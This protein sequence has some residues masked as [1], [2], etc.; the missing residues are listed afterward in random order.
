MTIASQKNI[1]GSSEPFS[2]PAEIRDLTGDAQLELDCQWS[3]NVNAFTQQA[4]AGDPWNSGYVNSQGKFVPS[5]VRSSYF[6]PATTDI[7]AGTLSHSIKWNAFPNRITTY[8]GANQPR[9]NP[10]NLTQHQLWQLG[11]TGYYTNAAGNKL[12]FPQIPVALY[13]GSDWNGALHPYGPYGPRGWQDEY[14]EWSVTRNS[15]GTI[16]RVDFVCENPEYW[17][18]LWRVSPQAVAQKYQDALNHGLPADSPDHVAVSAED[19]Y[20]ADPSSGQPVVDPFTGR[21]AYNPLNKWN[22]GATSTRGRN[23]SG[24]AIHLTSTPNTLHTELGLA[25]AATVQRMV[26]NVSAQPL[27]CCS[28]YGQE[29]RNSDPH[30]VQSVNQLVGG[31]PSSMVSL[32]N[33]VGLYIQMPNFSSY[34]LPSDPNLPAGASASDCWQIV[35]GTE[36]LTDPVTGQ[37]YP[38]NFILHAAFQVPAAWID[39]GVLFTV[40][41]ITISAGGEALPIH[42]ASQISETFDIGLFARALSVAAPTAR[43]CRIGLDKPAAP[44]HQAA[45]VQPMQLMYQALW[46]AYYN[47]PVANVIGF[48]MNLASNS[49]IVPVPVRQGDRGLQLVLTCGTTVG[50][51]DN[52]L[53]HVT[54]PGAEI[55]I[56]VNQVAGLLN[57]TYAAPGN[58]YP[59]GF[60]LLAL[61]VDVGANVKPGLYSV[62]V[63]NPGAGMPPAVPGPAF[64][65]VFPAQGGCAA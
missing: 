48:P 55:N 57:V 23:A 53:P 7:P 51:A 40:G 21:P 6:N 32:A 31:L 27:I 20:L 45:Q 49:V 33:P 25:G 39:A 38:G 63:S 24:G 19:L 43:S 10:Y 14:C 18:T 34:T 15:G 5:P 4:I 17:Y 52:L 50:G 44:P 16:T 37:P 62:Q 41:N 3:R 22:S 59:S 60:Q 26:G 58:S 1:D 46:N 47:T 61:T 54:V 12:T 29:H 11:D 30:I 35:R 2:T 13:P 64:L 42:W 8:C 56:T 9:T 36:T 28:R 65:N